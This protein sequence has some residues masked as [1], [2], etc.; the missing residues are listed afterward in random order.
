MDE[1][2]RLFAAVYG[3]A[4]RNLRDLTYAPGQVTPRTAAQLT[5]AMKGI[6]RV[7]VVTGGRKHQ[8]SAFVE[9]DERYLALMGDRD[10]TLKSTDDFGYS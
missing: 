10:F 4:Y 3:D 6:E 7:W 2:W 9:D 1:R 5:A 8:N